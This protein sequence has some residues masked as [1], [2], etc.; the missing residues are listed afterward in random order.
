MPGAL[1]QDLFS[2]THFPKLYAYVQRFD[3]A[4]ADAKAK[5]PKP[6]S[7]QGADAIKHILGAGFEKEIGFD[8]KDPLGLKKGQE[9]EVWPIDSG[10]SHRDRGRIVGVD[11]RELVVEVQSKEGGEVRLHFPRVGFR[12]KVI[13][14]AN[15]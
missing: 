3:Q 4:I 11:Q 9:V 12:V 10:F 13:Q 5:N 2:S 6:I 7:L 1:P 8:E 14:G 15:L